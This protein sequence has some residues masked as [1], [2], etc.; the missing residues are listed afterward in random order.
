VSL[1]YVGLLRAGFGQPACRHAAGALLPHHF[2]LACVPHKFAQHWTD[3]SPAPASARGRQCMSKCGEHRRYRFC[4][5]IRRIAPPGCYPALCPVELGLSSS[6]R[7][8]TRP[9]DTLSTR[10]LYPVCDWS[11]TMSRLVSRSAGPVQ[12][13]S[14][15]LRC[16]TTPRLSVIAFHWPWHADTPIVKGCGASL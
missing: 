14:C 6:R 11:A 1:P 8:G 9:P 13:S 10:R 15:A 16:V 5:T 12:L 4:A 2:T 7:S 3:L